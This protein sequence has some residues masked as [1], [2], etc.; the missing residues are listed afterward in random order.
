MYLSKIFC[1]QL[2]AK[3]PEL[4]PVTELGGHIVYASP[5]GEKKYKIVILYVDESWVVHQHDPCKSRSLRPI[6]YASLTG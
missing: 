6:F 1:I 4:L 2:L 3:Q 5:F